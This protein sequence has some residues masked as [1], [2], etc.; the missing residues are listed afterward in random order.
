MT[1]N[2]HKSNLRYEAKIIKMS[3]I[4]K[5]NKYKQKLNVGISQCV[6]TFKISYSAYSTCVKGIILPRKTYIN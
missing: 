6:L 4:S 3:T 2:F 5:Q 1:T